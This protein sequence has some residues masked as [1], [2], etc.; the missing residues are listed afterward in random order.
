MFTVIGTGPG[1]IDVVWDDGR[2][3][4]M[5]E[6]IYQMYIDQGVSVTQDESASQEDL[7]D[8]VEGEDLDEDF[9]DD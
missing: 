4:R 3:E 6:G 5:S 9:Y 2:S 1:F 8:D 7:F